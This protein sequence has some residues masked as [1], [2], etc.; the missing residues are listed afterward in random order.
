[1]ECLSRVLTVSVMLSFFSRARGEACCWRK[2]ACSC[3]CQWLRVG[4]AVWVYGHLGVLCHNMLTLEAL[5]LQCGLV[6]TFL[7]P[8]P[9]GHLTLQISWPRWCP[10]SMCSLLSPTFVSFSPSHY[11]PPPPQP[12]RLSLSYKDTLY[13]R[14]PATRASPLLSPSHAQAT[15]FCTSAPS[16]IR[17]VASCLPCDCTLNLQSTGWPSKTVSCPAIQWIQLHF[18]M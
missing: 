1:M 16:V 18:P 6:I 8:S 2:H 17:R 10:E 12:P 15:C 3:T 9:H 5:Q 14:P 4:P 11:P 7:W 13:S